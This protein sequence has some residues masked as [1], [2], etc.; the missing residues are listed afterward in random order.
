VKI[1]G[2]ESLPELVDEIKITAES[3]RLQALNSIREI[4]NHIKLR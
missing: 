2:W 4:G 3:S 1:Q